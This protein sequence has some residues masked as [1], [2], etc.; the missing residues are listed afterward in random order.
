MSNSWVHAFLGGQR[1]QAE[2]HLHAELFLSKSFARDLQ[3]ELAIL[4]RSYGWDAVDLPVSTPVLNSSGLRVLEQEYIMC[5]A[6]PIELRSLVV[7]AP[8]YPDP[9]LL[10]GT[11]HVLPKLTDRPTRRTFLQRLGR[12]LLHQF[13]HRLDLL[14]SLVAAEGAADVL[15]SLPNKTALA[16]CFYT[17]TQ[18]AMLYLQSLC[19]KGHYNQLLTV[20]L[21]YKLQRRWFPSSDYM[22]RCY[23]I[24]GAIERVDRLF[25]DIGLRHRAELLPVT[26]SNML[27]TA[28]GLQ[29][30]DQAYVS[31]LVH[32]WRELTRPPQLLPRRQLQVFERPVLCVA[33]ADLRMH[34]VGRFWLPLAELLRHRFRLVHVGFNPYDSDPVRDQ[35]QQLSDAWHLLDAN[36]GEA[37]DV[38]LREQRPDIL[39]DLGGHTADNRPGL[40]NQRYAPLQATYLG[41]YGPS[42]GEQCDWW[43]LDAAVSRHVRHSY[44]GCEPIWELNGPSLCY[45]PLAH[46][47]PSVEAIVYSEADHPVIGSFNHTRK[48]TAACIER[49]GLVLQAMPQAVLQFRSHSFYDP[50]VRRW[51]L[52]KFLDAGIEPHQLQPLPYAASGAEALNDYGRIQLHLDS[53]PVSGTTTTLDA[54]SMGIPV[55]TVPNHLYAGAISAAI[56]EQAGL[57][58]MVCERQEELPTLAQ[59]L[60]RQYASAKARR[61]LAAK[62]RSSAVCDTTEMPKMFAEQLGEMLRQASMQQVS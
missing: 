40:L 55:L 60:C 2:V 61:A 25:R 49:F 48:L 33:S 5:A 29:Q 3:S 21:H 50:A 7:R 41:F 39:L 20:Y 27:F 45:D 58:E 4:H 26:L 36:D 30:L 22:L 13:P 16:S 23:T 57:S 62:V 52:Q 59:R 35:L 32:H 56:L 24:V 54:L 8:E 18:P 31:Q 47:L 44:P 14:L 37:I 43:I 34:P 28:L 42:Y 10:W 1:L 11:W 15:K 19:V 6:D 9:L 53:Y 51:F 46:G 38:L 12:L 17:H